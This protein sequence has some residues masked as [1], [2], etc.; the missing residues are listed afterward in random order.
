[1][2]CALQ[3]RVVLSNGSIQQQVEAIAESGS[4]GGRTINDRSLE[5]NVEIGK[6]GI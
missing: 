1:V 3:S 5:E 2:F 4:E 6:L